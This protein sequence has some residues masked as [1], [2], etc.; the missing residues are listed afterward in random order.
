MRWTHK[1]KERQKNAVFVSWNK[2]IHLPW[3]GCCQVD[4]DLQRKGFASSLSSFTMK[5]SWEG[6]T[7]YHCNNVFLVSSMRPLLHAERVT[8]NIGNVFTCLWANTYSSFKWAHL[9]YKYSLLILEYI[10]NPYSATKHRFLIVVKWSCQAN[11]K[12]V[13]VIFL[14][15]PGGIQLC[16]FSVS[17]ISIQCRWNE[18]LFVLLN[19]PLKKKICCN[20]CIC[21]YNTDVTKVIAA[22]GRCSN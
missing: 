6:I 14:F 13:W 3:F 12:R 18:T 4:N 21:Y 15:T 8:K 9:L 2:H 19:N 11:Y 5:V 22:I 17:A 1:S 10:V 16:R 20:I 7:V